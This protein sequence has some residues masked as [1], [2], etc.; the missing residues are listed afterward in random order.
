MV[1]KLNRGLGLGP[2]PNLT[3]KDV[4]LGSSGLTA[5]DNSAPAGGGGPAADALLLETGDFY[6]LETGDFFL[7][8]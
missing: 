1:D 4:K 2:N 3:Q 6:L 8:E 5:K 7:L